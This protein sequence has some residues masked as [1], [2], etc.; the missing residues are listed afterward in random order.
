MPINY[1]D[2]PANWLYIRTAVLTRANH[3]CE[4]SPLH[5]DC[6]AANYQPHPVTGSRVVLTI[7]HLYEND[8][9]TQDLTRLHAWCQRCH[10]AYD[11]PKNRA[12]AVLTRARKRGQ[13]PLS[14]KSA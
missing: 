1:A 10:L 5:P 2:Y 8:H 14:G 6:R 13:L 12:R 7:A 11:R 9:M 3:C 4:G